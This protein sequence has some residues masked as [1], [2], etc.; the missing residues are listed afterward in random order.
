MPRRRMSL[1]SHFELYT[2]SNKRRDDD[3][4]VAVSAEPLLREG[5]FFSGMGVSNA[6]DFL[7]TSKDFSLAT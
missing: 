7:S 6:V 4:E 3:I 2:N 1:T 5:L